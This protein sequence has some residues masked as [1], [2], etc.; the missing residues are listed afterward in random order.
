M[1]AGKLTGTLWASEETSRLITATDLDV[2]IRKEIE[3]LFGDEQR[4][5]GRADSLD[6]RG[7]AS[8]T[9]SSQEKQQNASFI[10]RNRSM[11]LLITIKK[12]EM[13]ASDLQRA[14]AELDIDALKLHD[15]L[16][17]VRAL[18]PTSDEI[19]T[20]RTSKYNEKDLESFEE[21]EK[22]LVALSSVPRALNKLDLMQASL[23]LPPETVALSNSLATVSQAVTE[24]RSSQRLV[25]VLVHVARVC[26]FMGGGR[27]RGVK[28]ASLNR[29]EH[30]KPTAT[31]VGHAT[32]VTSLLHLVVKQLIR[33]EGIDSIQSLCNEFPTLLPASRLSPKKMSEELEHIDAEAGVALA[34]RTALDL[35]VMMVGDASATAASERASKA[36]TIVTESVSAVKQ[37]H[38]NM[39]TSCRQFAAHFGEDEASTDIQ[40]I[41]ISLVGF[42]RSM[43]TIIDIEMKQL[44]SLRNRSASAPAAPVSVMPRIVPTAV[45]ADDSVVDSLLQQIRL[46]QGL[47]RVR[48]SLTGSTAG[49][50]DTSDSDS[51]DDFD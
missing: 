44:A 5:S 39:C 49:D 23:S 35:E 21:A 43:Q 28:L 36:C 14:I 42:L 19:D 1:P 47:Q 30:T 7:K 24:I 11:T 20:I 6:V 16:V 45:A 13:G 51:D 27:H 31:R 3:Q 4:S 8:S 41:L 34:E 50:M 32:P 25:R 12:I 17:L 48:A 15:R 46:E 40:A 22:Y 10:D 29:L 2:S 9:I 38:E 18:L 37:K 26:N 33:S